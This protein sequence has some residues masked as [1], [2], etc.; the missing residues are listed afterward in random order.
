MSN[1]NTPNPPV[2]RNKAELALWPTKDGDKAILSGYATMDGQK[3]QVRAFLNDSDKEGNKLAHPYLSLTTNTAAEGQ[4]AQWKNVAYGNA[5]NKRSDGKDVYFDQV[6]FNVAG[7]EKTFNAY[8]GRGMN[9]DL[10]KQLGF[11]SPLVQR[12]A[13]EAATAPAEE[14][15]EAAS[16]RP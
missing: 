6:I 5:V 1:E 4:P 9:D 10:H 15:E 11:T 2:L 3:I 14:E 13:K 8:A 7:S 16:P 12:P